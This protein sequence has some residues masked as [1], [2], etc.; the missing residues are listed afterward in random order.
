MGK[1]T[2]PVSVDGIEF[3]ALI[4]STEGYEAEVPEYAVE[5]GF[6]VSDTI[7]L[8]PEKLDMTLF[9]S[10]R[11]VTW[12]QRLGNGEGRVEDVVKR[13][14]ELYFKRQLITVITSSETYTDMAITDISFPKTTNMMDAMEIPISLKKVRTT[15]T[16]TTTIPDSYGKSGATAAAAG[17]ASTSKKSSKAAKSSGSSGNAG[18]SGS[19][20]SSGGTSKSSRSSSSK[21]KSGSILYNLAKGVGLIK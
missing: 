11:P 7:S 17:T 21:E 20:S 19:S 9:L 16:K 14:K 6:C 1:A 8:K 2:Q 13:L 10:N 5:T 15:E 18:S 12:A 4:E 3:D